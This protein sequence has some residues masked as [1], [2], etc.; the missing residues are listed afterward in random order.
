MIKQNKLEISGNE[1]VVATTTISASKDG[2]I[3]A[4]AVIEN[5]AH[6]DSESDVPSTPRNHRKRSTSEPGIVP[7]APPQCK[8]RRECYCPFTVLHR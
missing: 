6:S 5:Q 7:N 3:T 8:R 2:V 1:R 4:R